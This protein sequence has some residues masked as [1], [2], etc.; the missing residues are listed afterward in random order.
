MWNSGSLAHWEY[1]IP[2]THRF[3]LFEM[4]LLG[5][6]GY[7]PFGLECVAVVQLFFPALFPQLQ[8]LPVAE[9]AAHGPLYPD[10]GPVDLSSASSSFSA[11]NTM[12]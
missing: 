2:F 3:Q 12:S 11:R 6:A 8:E 1:G 9:A 7:L 4:P 5:Y 10:K